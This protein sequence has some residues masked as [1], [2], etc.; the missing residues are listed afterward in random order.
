MKVFFLLDTPAE[1]LESGPVWAGHVYF[2]SNILALRRAIDWP[3]RI[4]AKG[5]GHTLVLRLA[6][7]SD[8]RDS[9]HLRYPK[10]FSSFR[11]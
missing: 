7:A 1:V 6:Q 4:L 11:H 8:L 9:T 10:M 3:K 5:G 2:V